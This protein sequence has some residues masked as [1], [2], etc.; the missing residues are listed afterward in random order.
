MVPRRR[1]LFIFLLTLTLLLVAVFAPPL[2]GLSPKGQRMVGIML[3]AAILW[4]TEWIPMPAT[5]LMVMLLQPLLQAMPAAEVFASFGNPAIFFLLGSLM[6]AA[7]VEKHGLHR[8]FALRALAIFDR[9]P[10]LFVFGVMVIGALLSFAMEEHAVAALLLPILMHILTTMRLIPRRSNFGAAVMLSL[11]LGTSI[12]SWGTLLGGARN[13]L[14]VGFLANTMGYKVT[15]L[16]WMR[17]SLP[18][19]LLALPLVWFTLIK[20]FPPEVQAQE[21]QLARAE[22]AREVQELGAM[23]PGERGTL[24]VFLTT[25][26]LWLGLSRTLGVAV[27][28][29]IGA[30]LLFLL[31]LVNWE[32]IESRVNW[33]IILLYGGAITLGIGLERTGAAEWI[34]SGIFLLSGGNPYVALLVLILFAFML[35]SMMS[36]TAAVALLLPIAL[37]LAFKIPGFSPIAAAFAVALSGGGGFLLVTATPSAA[38][39]YSS[40]YFGTRDLM[41]AGIWAIGICVGVIFLVANTYWRLIGLW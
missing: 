3:V 15:F 20:L 36:N 18:V 21:L 41:R 7:A 28:A 8:R 26:A 14:T 19:V 40:G 34:A 17:M 11:T 29:M 31:R 2:P 35:T 30:S 16:S 38:I 23:R 25:V 4:I 39:A 5:G 6:L 22:V 1:D 12:G 32:D 33:G 37:G 27:I 13:P 10:R 24:L 9:G